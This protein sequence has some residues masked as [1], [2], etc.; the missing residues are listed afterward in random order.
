MRDSLA[1]GGSVETWVAY[2]TPEGGLTLLE[3]YTG[4][5]ESLRWTRGARCVWRVRRLGGRL[6]AEGFAGESCCRLEGPAPRTPALQL[7]AR[8]APYLVRPGQG[9][10]L[11]A[12]AMENS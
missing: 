7:L 3:D 4:A 2:E 10:E 8:E 12:S 6:V 5:P 9:L 1:S 11:S